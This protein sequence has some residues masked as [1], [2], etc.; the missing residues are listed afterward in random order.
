MNE[1]QPPEKVEKPVEKVVEKPKPKEEKTEEKVRIFLEI[2]TNSNCF[3]TFVLS[4]AAFIF[5]DR[6]NSSKI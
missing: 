1:N 3:F 2:S 5:K 6:K 4:R